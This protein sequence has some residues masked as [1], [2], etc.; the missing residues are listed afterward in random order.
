MI[1]LW[2]CH[3]LVEYRSDNIGDAFLELKAH[4]SRKLI[5]GAM[6]AAIVRMIS[7]RRSFR[8]SRFQHFLPPTIPLGAGASFNEVFQI[9]ITSATTHGGKPPFNLAPNKKRGKK[10][11]FF[12][13][14]TKDS[15]YK[16]IWKYQIQ[17]NKCKPHPLGT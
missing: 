10:G 9:L 5:L 11:P 3:F 14:I 6:G 12:R 7:G 16:S 2:F 1:F 13:S 4:F 15:L 8:I 17:N